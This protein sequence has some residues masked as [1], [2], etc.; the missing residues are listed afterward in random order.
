[1]SASKEKI[2]YLPKAFVYH[3]IPAERLMQSFI[4]RRA[5]GVGKSEIIRARAENKKLAKVFT[6]EAIKWAGSLVLFTGYML[7]I[8]PSK[9]L[10][11]LK[12]RYFVSLG[13][14][15]GLRL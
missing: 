11:T 5:L 12:F 2:V 8:Q 6:R 10:M 1:M 14:I 13:M 3:F 4:T 7:R 15:N 9:G